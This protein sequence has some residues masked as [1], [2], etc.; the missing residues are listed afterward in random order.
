[1]R[2]SERGFSL[3]ELLVV[4]AILSIISALVLVAVDPATRLAQA[5]DAKRKNDINQIANALVAYQTLKG[6]FPTETSCDTSKGT[7]SITCPPGF[8]NDWNSAAGQVKNALETE[9]FLKTLP[10]DPVNVLKGPSEASLV[11]RYEPVSSVD[12][13]PPVRG[14]SCGSTP[15]RYWIGAVLESKAN[16]IFRCSDLETLTA[17]TGCKE[18]FVDLSQPSPFNIFL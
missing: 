14:V 2:S 4:I 5:R 17:G 16:T 11:Y 9:G 10:K 8:S 6:Q 13:N 1:M 3:V 7:F 15:C 12:S 18:V